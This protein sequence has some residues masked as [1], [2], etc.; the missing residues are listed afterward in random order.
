MAKTVPC[1]PLCGVLS[2]EEHRCSL[3]W[4]FIPETELSFGLTM[5]AREPNFCNA[6]TRL[7]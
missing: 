1:P 2:G 5:E 6:L 3:L 4:Q 7:S